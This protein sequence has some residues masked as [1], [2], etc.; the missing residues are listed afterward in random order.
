MNVSG[1]GPSTGISVG[2]TYVP[3][4]MQAGSLEELRF[5]CDAL[6]IQRARKEI[7]TKYPYDGKKTFAGLVAE[8]SNSV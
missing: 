8:Y 5:L 6:E 3:G 2:K 1:V 7:M 4:I